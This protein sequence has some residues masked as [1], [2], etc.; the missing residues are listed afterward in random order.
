VPKRFLFWYTP[1]GF[2]QSTFPSS[3]QLEGTSLAPLAP[4][5]DDLI[6]TRGLSYVSA[7]FQDEAPHVAG[8][9]HC[10]TGN[11][12]DTH[13]PRVERAD[14]SVDQFLAQRLSG[15]RLPMVLTGVG[16]RRPVSWDGSGNGV[17]PIEDPK[18][19]FDTLFAD[20]MGDSAERDRRR[21][22]RGSI[23]DA[24]RQSFG[25]MRC[26]LGGED[27]RRME[28]HLDQ[29]RDLESRVGSGSTM[30][31]SLPSEP[32][33][34]DVE[35]ASN[36]STAMRRH[37]EMLV[38]A[39]EC[40]LTRVG[41]LQW[42]NHTGYFGQRYE[43]DGLSVEHHEASHSDR[44]GAHT[45]AFAGEFAYL[46]EL[47]ANAEAED[48]ARMLDH[49]VVV[50]VTELGLNTTA[51]HLA[52]LGVVLAGSAGGHL[53]TG[54]YVDFLAEHRDGFEREPD[55]KAR[56]SG[57]SPSTEYFESF[58]VPHNNLW[59]ELINA[60]SPPSLE[61]VNTFGM[62]ELCSGGLPQLRA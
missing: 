52:D 35:A 55:W 19:T 39:F 37:M 47:L 16:A 43:W 38:K 2:Q 25:R 50:W 58:D 40:D 53:R 42:Y 61:P 11:V 24:V 3:L 6:V 29:L 48:G 10:L 59:V 5:R 33:G 18:Q 7:R 57:D 28:R 54:Q 45:E 34:I 17:L 21:T 44:H 60:V 30:C 51:H 15:T 62:P 9:A 23:A 46:L 1:N 4:H 56:A 36:H 13:E 20:L 22:R 41:G 8:Y 49:T 14:I 26:E 12:A 31:S 27:R 32:G